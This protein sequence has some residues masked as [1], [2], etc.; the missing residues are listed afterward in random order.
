MRIVKLCKIISKDTVGKAI[1]LQLLKSGTSIGA[2]L[3]EAY[4]AQ[5]KK[6]FICKLFIVLKEAR[7]TSYWLRLIK[8]SEMISNEEIEPILRESE[9]IKRIIGQSVVTAKKNMNNEE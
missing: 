7:E 3:E 1:T 2:N 8:E 5:S 9:E 6:D 4:G